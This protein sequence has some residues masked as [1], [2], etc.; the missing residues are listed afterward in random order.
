MGGRVEG[1]GVRVDVNE[2]LKFLGKY[3][4]KLKQCFLRKTMSPNH[5]PLSATLKI[6]GLSYGDHLS[7]NI[8]CA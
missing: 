6:M 2:E 1:G 3:S 7:K 5:L 4:K 8:L